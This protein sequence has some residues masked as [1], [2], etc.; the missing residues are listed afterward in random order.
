[1]TLPTI[2]DRVPRTA[3]PRAAGLLAVAIALS[4]SLP[5]LAQPQGGDAENLIGIWGSESS[6]GPKVRGELIVD[7]H[8]QPWQAAIA[9]FHL[10]VQQS[11]DAVTFVVPGGEGEF[12]GRLSSDRR[13]ILGHWI[14]PPGMIFNNAYASPVL[15]SGSSKSVWRGTVSPLEQ[16]VSLYLSVQRSADGTLTAFI[17]NPE[18]NF[19]RR[20]KFKVSQT[21]ATVML[22]GAGPDIAGSY[23]AESGTLSL[24]VVDFMPEFR[25]T[26]RTR[27]D[28][29][30]FFPRTSPGAAAD[31]YRRPATESDGWRTASLREV[32]LDERR[33]SA[34][35][36][37]IFSA[38]PADNPVYIHSLLIA[39]HGKLALE[40]YFYGFTASR[41]HDS[42]SA[43]KTLATVLAGIASDHGARLAP[44]TP[45]Y[46]LFPFYRN[47]FANWDDRKNRVLLRHIMSMTAG[48]ACDDN[49]DSSPGNEDRMQTQREQPDWYKY[50]L[51]LPMLRD[52]GGDH[53]IYCSADLNL[54]GGAVAAATGRWIPD[55]FAE[56][57]AR[58]LQF[59][60]YYLNLMPNGEAYMG[61]GAYLRPRDA[62][63]IGQLYL[64]GGTWNGRRVVS[65]A[66]VKESTGHQSTFTPAFQ[67]EGQHEYGFG[68]HIHHLQ[69]EG[70]SFRVYAAE[71]NGGQFVVVVPDLDMV[72]AI[73]G[74]SYGEFGK[75]YR[76]ELDLVPQY[77][78]AAAVPVR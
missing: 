46:A 28:A 31:V 21:D 4:A 74:G 38:D 9:G 3:R 24:R 18:M 37:K 19:F 26:R 15:L 58:P 57:L 68:W 70:R 64:S 76:W 34:L 73:N 39:R 77:I 20:R 40:E 45:L 33:I 55:V 2:T 42:R 53:G 63:K 35:I 75:W 25:F 16:R 22:S 7:A 61:G 43:G 6:F 8:A 72:I 10:P 65:Q 49:D 44:D 5:A 62:L 48:N 50:S 78:L 14:Q 59:G 23:E 36:E 66:W 47:A 1:M 27:Q 11:G 51:D 17:S 52:P 41:T 30:G 69:A 71:G 56:Y 13:A 54:V 29:A 67:D 32:G 12:R 60:P